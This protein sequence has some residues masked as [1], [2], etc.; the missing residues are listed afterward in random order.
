LAVLSDIPP[1]STQPV[2]RQYS[3]K[4]LSVIVQ[5]EK[6]LLKVGV[7]EDFVPSQGGIEWELN[8]NYTLSVLDIDVTASPD[9]KAMLLLAKNGMAIDYEILNAS[10]RYL[11][12][13]DQ[14]LIIRADIEA[15]FGGTGS[16]LAKLSNVY[17]YSEYSPALLISNAI[18]LYT[19]GNPEI[20]KW[21]LFQNYSLT[22]MDIDSNTQQRQVWLRLSKG[23]ETIDDKI[24]QNGSNAAFYRNNSKILNLSVGAIFDGRNADLVFTSRIYQYSETDINT[25]LMRNESHNFIFGGTSG[26]EWQLYDNYIIA[27]MDADIKIIPPQTW[28]RM[29]KNGV[30]VD[31]KVLAENQTYSYSN[32]PGR[33][34]FNGKIDKLFIGT[35][36]NYLKVVNVYQ[37]S[38]SDST[39]LLSNTIHSFYPRN[40]EVF[41]SS[42]EKFVLYENYSII[43]ID[44]SDFR[45]NCAKK[46]G[47]D[48]TIHAKEDIPKRIREI[49]SARLADLVILCAGAKSAL[50]CAFDSV[51]RGG[52]ILI[53]AATEKD[54][55]IEKTVNDIF[56]RN[57][58]TLISSYAASPKEHLEALEL[59]R[60]RKINQ[61]EP[62]HQNC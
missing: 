44:I 9:R 55:K 57:E 25:V 15:V 12:Y 61:D 60:Q 24:I 18:H 19:V 23:D 3:E 7:N 22:A 40:L 53:F 14:K 4:N 49:N 2:L 5:N 6:A 13:K 56:W 27:F 36:I 1:A 42:S 28:L 26:I 41:E 35:N 10:E 50:A 20:V 21:Q 11:Y 45:L 62:R 37:Y 58:I 8:E 16:Y 59:I 30:P 39:P 33:L 52:T 51:E 17:Q 48:Y 54:A 31:D 43:A 34:I 29:E 47:A 46:F 38:E 32:P